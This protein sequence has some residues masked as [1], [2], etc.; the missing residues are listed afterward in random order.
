LLTHPGGVGVDDLPYKEFVT[1]VDDL[2]V[3]GTK[4][5][6]NFEIE[7]PE[8]YLILAGE[9]RLQII[10]KFIIKTLNMKYP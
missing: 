7:K 1:Y 10:L 3:H 4:I 5:E 8:Y 9:H 6:N 2:N